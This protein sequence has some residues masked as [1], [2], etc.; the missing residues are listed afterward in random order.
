[1]FI[2]SFKKKL[3]IEYIKSSPENLEKFYNSYVSY[4]YKNI[5]TNNNTYDNK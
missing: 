2:D 4:Y 3:E 5:A 1:M